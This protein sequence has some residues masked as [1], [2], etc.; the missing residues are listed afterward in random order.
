[1]SLDR[2][3]RDW[4]RFLAAAGAAGPAGLGGWMSGALAAGMFAGS[5]GVVRV[6][7]SAAVNGK[8]AR[9][10]APV[11]PGD[12][13][14][15]GKDGQAVF[16]VGPDA[17]L[18][19]GDTVVETRGSGGVLTAIA[20]ANGKLLSVFGKKPMAIQAGM[21]AIGIRGTGAYVEVD[22]ARA[23]FCLCYGEATIDGRNMATKAVKTEHHESPLY[24]FDDGRAL[25]AEPGPFLNHSD[26]E[27]VMLEA[28]VG[29][30]PPF[31]KS[32]VYPSKQY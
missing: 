23:Y 7:G 15:T 18:M 2:S 13:L 4:L 11:Q 21:A 9:A 24:L 31:V 19:R 16:V 17:F 10:G 3:R 26:A 12:K 8:P 28:L 1:M 5:E 6:Q 29:R 14:T 32:G 25:R 20:V 30:E 22:P 27:L